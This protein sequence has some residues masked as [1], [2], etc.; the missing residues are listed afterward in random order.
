[1]AAW[2]QIGNAAFGDVGALF[3]SYWREF[4]A[5]YAVVTFA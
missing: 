1:M 5:R 3:A 2:R 4:R